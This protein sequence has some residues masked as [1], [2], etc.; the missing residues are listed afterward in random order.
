M[1][2]IFETER[3]RIEKSGSPLANHS[4]NQRNIK[5]GRDGEKRLSRILFLG[6]DKAS[7]ARRKKAERV[8]LAI[9]DC[10]DKEL[11]KRIR[12]RIIFQLERVHKHSSI[13][14]KVTVE[15]FVFYLTHRHL[16]PNPSIRR[17]KIVPP[18]LRR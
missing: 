11:E 3:R 8:E 1:S 5:T 16:H 10:Y 7:R 12:E 4:E 2:G 6:D 17:A 13:D 18:G 14:G 9:D 15:E